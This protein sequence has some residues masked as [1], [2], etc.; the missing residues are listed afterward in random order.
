MNE[1]ESTPST[2]SNSTLIVGGV[3]LGIV[4][5][6]FVLIG[7]ARAGNNDAAN[8]PVVQPNQAHDESVPHSHAPESKNEHEPHDESV[9][10]SH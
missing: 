6:V 9:P 4:I 3:A 5:L 7:L 1:Q 8:V 2:S 10:H